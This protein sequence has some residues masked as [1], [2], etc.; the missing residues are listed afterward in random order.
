MLFIYYMG[1]FNKSQNITELFSWKLFIFILITP[2]LLFHFI[3][4]TL[5][6]FFPGKK[7]KSVEAVA[8]QQMTSGY[9]SLKTFSFQ[10]QTLQDSL[11]N[12][13]P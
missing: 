10:T 7:K 6:H 8:G 9:Y 4:H 5:N 13:L 1:F 12:L 2:Y 11:V 3:F